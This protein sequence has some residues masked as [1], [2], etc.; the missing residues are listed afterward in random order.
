MVPFYGW[1]STTSRLQSHREERFAVNHVPWSLCTHLSTVKGRVDE[2]IMKTPTGIEPG[3]WIGNPANHYDI[4]P[5]AVNTYVI[6]CAI[7]YHLYNLKNAKNTYGGMLLLVKL[8]STVTKSNI[9]P[10]VFFTFFEF[11]EWYQIAQNVSYI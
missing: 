1:S 6:L 2:S 10:W 3:T 8:Q 9:L 5:L 7:W 11:C 4:G